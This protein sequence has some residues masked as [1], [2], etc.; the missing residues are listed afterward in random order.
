MQIWPG[1]P[2][3]LG[4]TYDGSGTNFALFSSAADRVELADGERIA[5]GLVE[6]NDGFLL[7]V[8]TVFEGAGEGACEGDGGGGAIVE[9]GDEPSGASEGKWSLR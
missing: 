1:Q 6:N 7:W 3:P 5:R 4:A 8:L 2:Y 9:G